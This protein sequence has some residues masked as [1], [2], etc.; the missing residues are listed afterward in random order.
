MA[1]KSKKSNINSEFNVASTGLNLDGSQNNIKK[2]SLS[3]AL[4]AA[5]E[6]YDANSIQYQNEPGNEACFEFPSGYKLISKHF[7][8]E[9]NKI[10]FFLANPETGGSEIGFMVN[11]DCIYHTLVNADCLN[12]SIEQN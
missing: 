3:Y 6:N 12:F 8:P 4:N 11:N 2:G 10:I 9:Q 5:L 1:E 7:I